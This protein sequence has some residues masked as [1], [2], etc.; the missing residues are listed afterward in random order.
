MSLHI[1][2]C[3]V[4][5]MDSG[6]NVPRHTVAIRHSEG[7]GCQVAGSSATTCRGTWPRVTIGQS[8]HS[9]LQTF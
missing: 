6:S 7:R 1:L 9:A 4:S 8:R 3:Q 5:K 2:E